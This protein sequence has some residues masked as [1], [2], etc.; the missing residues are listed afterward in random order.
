MLA[1]SNGLCLL[2]DLGWRETVGNSTYERKIE[3][4]SLREAQLSQLIAV[5]EMGIDPFARAESDE[6]RLEAI[7]KL[8]IVEKRKAKLLR[9][10]RQRG[11]ARSGL[12]AARS[13][14]RCL[15]CQHRLRP[16]ARKR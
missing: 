14:L 3:A 13:K 9:S 1:G 10:M 16:C 12:T 8:I 15:T 2:I 11:T 6:A 4:K 5:G 7:S